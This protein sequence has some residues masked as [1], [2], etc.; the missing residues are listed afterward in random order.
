MNETPSRPLLVVLGNQLFPLSHFEAQRNVPVFMAEDFGLCTY[1]RH[2]QQK[3]VLFLAAMRSFRDELEGAGFDVRYHELTD[4]SGA[5]LDRLAEVVESGS[6]RRASDVRSRGQGHGDGPQGLRERA[7]ASAH[8]ARIADVFVF[9]G[10]F[11][12]LPQKA[13]ADRSWRTSTKPS[14]AG[15]AYC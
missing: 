2:H 1:V 10:A 5:F 3:I 6:S 13:H 7:R 12:W 14:A 9:E 4:G 11:C 8:G 15:S